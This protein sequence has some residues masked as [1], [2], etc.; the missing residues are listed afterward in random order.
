MNPLAIL[1]GVAGGYGALRLGRGLLPRPI[2]LAAVLARADARMGPRPIL[3]SA[4]T[5]SGAAWLG[6]RAENAGRLLLPSVRAD[7]HIV[8]KSLAHHVGEKVSLALAGVL[9][10]GVWVAALAIIGVTPPVIP[11]AIVAIGLAAFGFVVPDLAVRSQAAVRRREFRHGQALYVWL[12]T[13]AL[14]GGSGLDSALH[15]CAA[16]GFPRRDGAVEP[17]ASGSPGWVLRHIQAAVHRA[18]ITRQPAW[19]GLRQLAEEVGVAELGEVASTTALAEVYGARA[20]DSLRAKAQSLSVRVR[21]ELERLAHRGTDGMI[22]PVMCFVFGL[23][24]LFLYPLFMRLVTT[25]H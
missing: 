10:P 5:R 20:R 8:G 4:D 25:T 7:L 1:S 13:S 9:L 6:R 23:L 12:V 19:S 11:S 22:G 15:D 24:L 21:S 16:V 3:S 14:A 2:P 18:R 17:G